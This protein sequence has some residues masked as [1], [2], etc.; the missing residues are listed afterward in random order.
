M[1]HSDRHYRYAQHLFDCA[2]YIGLEG[3]YSDWQCVTLFYSCLHFCEA[4]VFYQPI[5]ISTKNGDREFTNLEEYY[6]WTTIENNRRITKHGLLSDLVKRRHRSIHPQYDHMLGVAHSIRYS[7]DTLSAD[8]VEF[9]K[10][11]AD[12]IRDYVTKETRG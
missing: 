6:A 3:A 9:I 1:N 11:N 4:V 2:S 8:E 5:E 10:T 12:A 7:C